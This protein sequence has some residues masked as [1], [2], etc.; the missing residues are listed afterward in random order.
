M[1]ENKNNS[2]KRWQQIAND[3]RTLLQSGN[4]RV[5]DKFTSEVELC[6]TYRES[7]YNVRKAVNILKKQGWLY[8]LPKS[9]TFVGT[10][11]TRKAE[12]PPSLPDSTGNNLPKVSL[13]TLSAHSLQRQMWYRLNE[14]LEST[15]V[16]NSL[17]IRFSFSIEQMCDSDIYEV[18]YFPGFFREK[19]RFLNIRS[20]FAAI[21]DTSDMCDDYSVPLM[22][23]SPVI[24]CNARVLQQMGFSLPPTTS[25]QAQRQYLT[26]VTQE[27]Q[28]RNMPMPGSS[29]V[30]VLYLGHI[31]KD[32]FVSFL[33]KN[34]S[35]EHFK[36]EYGDKIHQATEYFRQFHI[37]DI[38]QGKKYT[39]DF[40]QEKTP[41]YFCDSVAAALMI[42]E[43]P[44]LDLAKRFLLTPG[45]AVCR[46]PI[47]Y[48]VDRMT[49]YPVEAIQLLHTCQQPEVQEIL[50]MHG[51]IP[52]KPALHPKMLSEYDADASLK[53]EPLLNFSS[54]EEQYV[55]MNIINIEMWKIILQGK[56][57]DDALRDILSLA[58]S[59]LQ[60]SL[61]K[62]SAQAQKNWFLK[63]TD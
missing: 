34:T 45:D 48:C 38:K 50:T 20:Y 52:A 40:I 37:C 55:I 15:P 23:Y 58:P 59:Y 2:S 11:K 12:V 24:L 19:N 63:Q 57:E 18:N 35:F 5:G 9:G 33:T 51:A 16:Q 62:Q 3:L 29:L 27:I 13:M 26:A 47:M 39:S 31:L 7:V 36:A 6:K 49:P 17:E 60:L 43:Y 54:A 30:P 56:N 14:Y 32:I 25:C 46:M 10:P 44:H 1:M 53:F 4:F 28:A 8:S 42:D 22:T 61:D 41:F 21:L